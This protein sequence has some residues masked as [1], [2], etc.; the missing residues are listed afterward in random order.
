MPYL[1]YNSYKIWSYN[2][3]F[4]LF[5]ILNLINVEIEEKL[6]RAL[7]VDDWDEVDETTRGYLE[8]L[9]NNGLFFYDMDD[10]VFEEHLEEK[11]VSFSLTPILECNLRC[12]Y[13][14]ADAGKKYVGEKRKYSYDILEKIA[15]YLIEKYPM[16]K[17]YHLSFVSGGEPFLDKKGLFD[18]IDFMST[19]FAKHEKLLT[20][21]LCTNG[22]LIDIED[23]KML[24]KYNIQ[25]GISQDG[26]K[27]EHDKCR[28][29]K[30]GNGTYDCVAEKINMILHSGELSERIR[31]IW[32]SAVITS[33]NQDMLSVLLEH[34][35]LGIANSQ[36]RFIQSSKEKNLAIKEK[37][38]SKVYI[39]IEELITFLKNELLMGKLDSALMILNENDSIGKIIRRLIIQKPY[40]KRCHAGK[41]HFAFT[42]E[43][44]IYPCDNFVGIEE[45]KIGSVLTNEFG[46]FEN[47]SVLERERCKN[48]WIRFVCGGDCYYNSFC[49]NHDTRVPDEV[50]CKIMEYTVESALVM[51]HEIQKENLKVYSELKKILRLKDTINYKVK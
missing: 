43:G 6:Y 3:R 40:I 14:F 24:D 12:R 8:K 25:I 5:D 16:I 32:G 22:T 38:L 51:L 11:E 18:M 36:L 10:I 1:K 45:F 30:Y 7:E 19:F 49:C 23:L 33:E 46:I 47:C 31:K 9:R 50:F 2:N 26:K 29:D 37:N 34:K 21:W 28:I 27:T 13:C 4:F 39:W 41:L 35:K 44:D 42:P 17:K 48:C 20:M 15:I